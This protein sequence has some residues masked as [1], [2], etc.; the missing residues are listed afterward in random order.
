MDRINQIVSILSKMESYPPL[1][2]MKS[3]QK[4]SIKIQNYS[5]L[6]CL[7]CL[8][9]LGLLIITCLAFN[10]DKKR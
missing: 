9:L 6:G 1:S 4:T 5:L 10:I 3:K 8:L 7:F 2:T